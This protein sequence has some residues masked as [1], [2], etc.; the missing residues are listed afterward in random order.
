M[1]APQQKVPFYP[2]VIWEAKSPEAGLALVL[3]ADLELRQLSNL[4]VPGS[5][6]S[7]HLPS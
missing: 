7:P 4:V 2:T 6:L 5:T 1:R 3:L